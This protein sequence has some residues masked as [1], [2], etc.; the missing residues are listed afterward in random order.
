MSMTKRKRLKYFEKSFGDEFR[1][2]TANS[3]ADGLKL[4]EEHGDDIGVLL[5][6]QRMPG[7]KGVQ[8]LEKAR[9]S[10]ARVSSA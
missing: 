4:I 1:I 7:E 3:A 5:S 8:L 10:C 9:F 6:D 2:L